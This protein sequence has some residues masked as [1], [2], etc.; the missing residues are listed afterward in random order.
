MRKR[1]IILFFLLVPVTSVL[2]HSCICPPCPRQQFR[3][4][5]HKSLSLMNLDNSGARPVESELLQLN[6]NAF[7]IRLF[8][9]AEF[10]PALTHQSRGGSFLIQSAYAVSCWCL[11]EFVYTAKENILSITILTLNDFDSQHP[12]N[13]DVTDLFRV[14]RSFSTIEN[15]VANRPHSFE[16]DIELEFW[17]EQELTIDLLLMF[18]PSANNKQQFEVQVA[19]SDGRILKQQTT[20]I[21]LL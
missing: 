15:F 8:L 21:E 4:F 3:D 6:K 12:A 10:S 16:V 20:E 2:F 5:T 9:E 7:G 11:P 19:L 14:A 13:S 1:A 17:Q 18:P